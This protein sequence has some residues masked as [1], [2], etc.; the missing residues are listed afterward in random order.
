MR[1]ARCSRRIQPAEAWGLGHADRVPKRL[2]R[3]AGPEHRSC[4]RA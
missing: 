1:C 2:G 3:Y 4:N